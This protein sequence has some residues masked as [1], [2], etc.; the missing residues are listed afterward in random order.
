MEPHLQILLAVKND[1]LCF[2]FPILDIHF[3]S[4]QDDGDV[5]TDSDQISVPVWNVLVGHSS[6]HIEHY[7][8]TLA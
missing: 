5:L 4:T 8:S 6:C 7:D 1:G 2:D 3:I